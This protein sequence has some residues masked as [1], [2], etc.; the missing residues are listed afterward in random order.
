MAKFIRSFFPLIVIAVI[1]WKITSERPTPSSSPDTPPATSNVPVKYK[2]KVWPPV[3][4]GIIPAQNM[5]AKN[6]YVL[7][8]TSG[9]MRESVAGKVKIEAARTAML[10]FSENIADDVNL[11][12]TLFG[13]IQEV[14]PLGINNRATFSK[15]ANEITPKGGTPLI[16]AI[17]K[18]YNALTAQ[19][20]AQGGYGEY[21]LIIVTDGISSDGDPAPLAREIV[22]HSAINVQVIGFG[23]KDH[24]LNIP[25]YTTYTSAQSLEELIEALNKTIQAETEEFSDTTD[26][27]L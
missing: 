14:V 15:A 1:V 22:N 11:G 12:L 23:L 4:D 3:A 20:Q 21:H 7:L 6:Y 8:D 24:S 17:E 25:G 10:S 9:S 13:P 26:F 19:A 18:G 16:Q 5:T 2:P 27:R